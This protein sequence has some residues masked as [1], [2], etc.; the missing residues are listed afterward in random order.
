MGRQ[1]RNKSLHFKL[2]GKE[3]ILYFKKGNIV[4]LIFLVNITSL[5]NGP[6]PLYF[7]WPFSHERSM[8]KFKIY[9]QIT[10]F[11]FL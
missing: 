11:T 6:A 3:S 9:Y 7:K 5:I 10:L 4:I 1:H 8:K 2:D